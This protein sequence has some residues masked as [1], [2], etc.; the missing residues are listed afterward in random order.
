VRPVLDDADLLPRD[1]LG[2]VAEHRVVEVDLADDGDVRID[3]VRRVPPPTEADLDDADVDGLVGEV[4]ERHRGHQLEERHRM[5]VA[6][7]ALDRR[8]V[9]QAR[10]RLDLLVHLGEHL[11]A[12]GRS[13]TRMRSRTSWRCGETYVPV[14][15]PIASS[16]ADD[17]PDRRALAVRAGDVD[18]AVGVLR[19]AEEPDAAR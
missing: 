6:A 13:P 4:R 8:V 16:S 10:E 18:G 1:L 12:I 7:V 9:H 15:R 14:R 3:D 11:G 19:V 17:D 5:R 2:R